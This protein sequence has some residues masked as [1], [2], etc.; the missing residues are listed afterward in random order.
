MKYLY[1][2]GNNKNNILG[3]ESIKN[4]SNSNS[5]SN[6]NATDPKIKNEI[7]SYPTKVNGSLKNEII[8]QVAIGS[9]YVIALTKDHKL[10]SWG[11]EGPWLGRKVNRVTSPYYK[12]SPMLINDEDEN[13]KKNESDENRVKAEAGEEEEEVKNT[14]KATLKQ[15]QS[16]NKPI[17][18]ACGEKHSIVITQN[19]SVF[20]C[21]ESYMN[22]LGCRRQCSGPDVLG[23]VCGFEDS[24]AVAAIGGSNHTTVIVTPPPP[25]P[26]PS[27]SP[28]SPPPSSS[29]SS[30]S[31]VESCIGFSRLLA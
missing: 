7:I 11:S 28:S 22:K 25:S 9:H 17:S 15:N 24:H 19:G 23:E 3:L 12:P 4:S 27:S 13:E 1:L 10:F 8:S 20:T 6:S 21:G 30:S 31:L 29:P 16:K 18:V 26:P 14:N 2:W 5:N